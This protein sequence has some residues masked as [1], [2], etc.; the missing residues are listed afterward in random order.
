MTG[1][2]RKPTGRRLLLSVHDGAIDHDDSPQLVRARVPPNQRMAA[3]V[4]IDD[5]K[6]GKAVAIFKLHGCERS[7]A[8][9]QPLEEYLD[10]VVTQDGVPNILFAKGK[11]VILLRFS[12]P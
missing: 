12:T 10:S 4:N 5:F 9:N 3:V 2:G 7:G 8:L 11:R 1:T 6:Q